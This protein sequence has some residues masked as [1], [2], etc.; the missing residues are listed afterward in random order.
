MFLIKLF[1]YPICLFSFSAVLGACTSSSG[2]NEGAIKTVSQQEGAGLA[3][4]VMV[5]ESGL[6]VAQ[7]E[8][9]L[10]EVLSVK[11]LLKD[12]MLVMRSD[13]DYE[14]LTLQNF[15]KRDR[16]YSH[17]GLLFREGDTFMVYHSM[18]GLEN[19]SGTIRRDAFDSFVNPSQKTGFGLFQYRLN[20]AETQKLHTLM[21]K[22]YEEKIPFDIFFNLHSDDSLYC[23]EMIYK[24]IRTA[25]NGRV[26]LPFS[27]ILDFHPKIM[28]YKHNDVRFKRFEY[29][30]LDDLYLNPFCREVKRVA[31]QTNP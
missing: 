11:P 9:S 7:M 8:A 22:G 10:K 12:A 18:T 20:P 25:S 14:S 16:I 23:S 28:G 6:T 13:N 17:A 24:N 2:K 4:S 5:R 3:D 26:V 30:G 27:Y 15:S 29:I 1:R 31:Y 21:Q 19:P